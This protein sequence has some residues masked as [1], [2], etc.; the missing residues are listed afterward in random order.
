MPNKLKYSSLASSFR[1]VCLLIE[2]KGSSQLSRSIS[3]K[4]LPRTNALACFSGLQRDT[5]FDLIH[6]SVRLCCR[7]LTETNSPAYLC[8]D[9]LERLSS[10]KTLT[11][12]IRMS[13]GMLKMLTETESNLRWVSVIKLQGLAMSKYMMLIHWSI[14]DCCKGFPRTNTGVF[15]RSI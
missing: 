4:G 10:T 11:S 12:L 3:C 9:I 15:V 8:I 1:S 13:M 14:S 5:T 7:G 6:S 2:S